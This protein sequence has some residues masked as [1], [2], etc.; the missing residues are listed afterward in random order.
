LTLAFPYFPELALSPDGTNLV[1]SAKKEDALQPPN[2]LQL[3]N[4]EKSGYG[5]YQLYR[6]SLGEPD[7][8]PIA[9]TEG[10]VGPMFSPDGT[11]IAFLSATVPGAAVPLRKV[12]LTGGPVQTLCASKQIGP[13]AWSPDETIFFSSSHSNGLARVSSAGGNCQ[14]LTAPDRNHAE[15]VHMWPQFVPGG[16]ALLFTILK[17]FIA[18]QASVAVLSLKT[19]Q[20]QTLIQGGAN[21]HYVPGGYLVY[22]RDGSLMSVPFDR[23]TL[24]VTG[25]PVRVLA[26]LMT[27]S[28]GGAAQFTFA[29]D[30]TMAYIAGNGAETHRRVVLVGRDGKSQVLTPDEGAYE[31]LDLSPDGRRIAL[32]IQGPTWHIWIYDIPRGTLTRL[33]FDHDNRDPHWSADGKRVAYTSIRN[34]K[35]GLYWKPADGSGPE[36]QLV[37]DSVDCMTAESF[38]P[39]GKYLAYEITPTQTGHDIWILPLSGDRE[40]RPFAT[41][42]FNEWGPQFSPDGH[43]IS[44]GSDESGRGEIYVR[45][46]PGPGGKSQISTAGGDRAVWSSEGTELFYRNGSKQMAVPVDIKHGLTP[47]APHLLWEGNYFASGHY[48]GVMPGAKQFVFIKEMEQP[49]GTTEIHVVL[50]WFDELKQRMAAQKQ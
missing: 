18:E 28:E 5:S 37:G 6:R 38:S 36:E 16:E 49:H 1:F 30:G 42:R 44:Y 46:F 41:E 23:S 15:T 21:P 48:F 43:W 47:G 39:D 14:D 27:N 40:P 22:A 34:G 32:T 24:K 29:P 4:A 19:G 20:W 25:S 10:G 11:S 35:C 7:A 8:K 12:A 3:Q 9:G 13:G 26:D 50:N 33:T 2:A 31:D 45:P 17:G